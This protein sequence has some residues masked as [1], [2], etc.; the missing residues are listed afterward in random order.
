MFRNESRSWRILLL[1]GVGIW[2]TLLWYETSAFECSPNT[3]GV[4]VS[5][6]V[7]IYAW[8]CSNELHSGMIYLLN[9]QEL[10]VRSRMKSR[11]TV[12]RPYKRYTRISSATLSYGNLQL[13]LWPKKV[14]HNLMIWRKHCTHKNCGVTARRC[15]Y[16]SIFSTHITNPL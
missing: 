11:N 4:S 1:G 9:F 8:Y 12:R 7:S 5:G 14:N 2:V 15:K 10:A 16:I 13:P 6:S 3:S